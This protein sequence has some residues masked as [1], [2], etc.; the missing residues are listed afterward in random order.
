MVGPTK[1]V[2]LTGASG[3][4]GS[5]CR[6]S[7]AGRYALRLADVRPLSEATGP[8]PGMRVDMSALGPRESF[9]QLDISDYAQVAAAC[10]GV[11]VVV[12]LA[13]DPSGAAEFESVLRL[14]VIGGYNIFAAAHA[15]GC[16]RIVMA[17]T[18][19][20]LPAA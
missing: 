3:F 12:H 17:S 14:N 6:R 19:Q 18:T 20:V 13:A 16:S 9:V 7:W 1:V 4:V 8:V 11:D 2:L 5:L 10:E 15:A